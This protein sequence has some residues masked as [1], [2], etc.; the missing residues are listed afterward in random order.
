MVFLR[1][2]RRSLTNRNTQLS[3]RYFNSQQQ[4]QP[5]LIPDNRTTVALF[6]S[7]CLNSYTIVKLFTKLK[8]EGKRTQAPMAYALW[9]V[10]FF[11]LGGFTLVPVLVLGVLV[12]LYWTLPPKKAD[13]VEREAVASLEQALNFQDQRKNS[14]AVET[15]SSSD[16][17]DQAVTDSDRPLSSDQ[18]FDSTSTRAQSFGSHVSSDSFYPPLSTPSL[19]IE[20]E[21]ETGVDAHINGWLTVSREYFIYPTGGP[22]NSGNPPPPAT[23]AAS[24]AQN[25]GAYSSL[26]KLVSNN[27]SKFSFSSQSGSTDTVSANGSPN[28]SKKS[29]LSKYFAVLRHGNLF[30]YKDADQKDVKHVVV[31]AHYMVTMWPPQVPDGQLFV[32]RNAICLV[33]IPMGHGSVNDSDNDLARILSDPANPPKNAFYLYLDNCSEKEDFYFALVRASKK[34]NIHNPPLHTKL[35]SRHSMFNPIYQAHPLHYKTSNMMDLIQTLHSTDANIQTR[36]LNAL[37]GR[38]FLALNRTSTFEA[39][40]RN[41]IIHKLSRTKK[42]SFLSE[43][44]VTKIYS[45]DSIPYFTNPRLVELTPEGRLRV[46]ADITYSGGFSLE[47]A[48]KAII[49][50][51]S[52]FKTREVSI[53]LAITLQRLEGKLVLQ[54]KAPPSDRLWYAFEVM[55]KMDLLVEPIVSS[56]QIKY[57]VITKAIENR[58]REVVSVIL[59]LFENLHTN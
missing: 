14:D 27:S 38:L 40:F 39:Y 41:K 59:L 30:L 7:S 28:V 44:L 4:P 58:I 29:R 11:V 15:S 22:N 56:R 43:I 31:I 53:A 49:N 54:M 24:I 48:T 51:G 17:A 13:A 42:P 26:Y 52:R 12:F 25:E 47:I 50:L 1:V 19:S 35:E 8:E 32:K 55:P 20:R 6:F 23:N 5:P 2:L 37:L 16:S 57:S 34:Y 10:F 18:V 21:H 9:F 33:K 45:G 3:P 46:E 36:W